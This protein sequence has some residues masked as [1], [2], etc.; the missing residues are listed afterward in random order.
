MVPTLDVELSQDAVRDESNP[1]LAYVDV[2]Q[3]SIF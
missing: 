1:R 2:D 3:E